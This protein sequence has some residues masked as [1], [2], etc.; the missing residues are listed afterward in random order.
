MRIAL[1][2]RKSSESED[3]QV[4]SLEDQI[5][6]LSRLAITEGHEL[7]AVLQEAKS[8]KAPDS[9]PEFAR[10]IALIEAGKI[11]GI[12]TWSINRLSRN[13]VDGGRLAYML[14]TGKLS[15]I[16]TVDRKYLPDDNALLLSIENGMA[17]AYLQDL[18]RNVTRGM[19]GKADRG[20]HV[21]KAPV[22]YLN[23][24]ITRE[25][26]VDPERFPIVQ[27]AWARLLSGETSV[28]RLYRELP[29]LTIA[30]RHG[31][32]RPL[33]RAGLHGIFKNPI[34]A[35]MIKFKGQLKPGKHRAMVTMADFLRA[36]DLIKRGGNRKTRL[37]EAFPFAGVFRC[38]RCGSAVVGERRRKFYPRTGRF[39]EY[40]YYHCSGSKGCSK[41]AVR[42]EEVTNA[43]ERLCET[44]QL[45]PSF[46]GWL[47]EALAKAISR[48]G[49]SADVS[50]RQ[51]EEET[52]R[53]EARRRRL[54]L[55]RLDGEISEP[56]YQE[57]RTQLDAD[58]A[59][60][61]QDR[62]HLAQTRSK[63]IQKG[64]DLLDAA[65]A[66]GELPGGSRFLCSLG[67]I[68]R[69]LGSHT[70]IDGQIKLK[71]DPI[72]K[73]IALFEPAGEGSRRPKQGDLLPMSS[74]WWT[75]VDDLL[76]LMVD[77]E[78]HGSNQSTQS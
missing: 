73:K 14:Q 64:H 62:I 51:V 72:Y 3:K 11:D 55:L 32:P 70:L 28:N 57:L 58:R 24:P 22:G 44:V 5:S 21:S 47:K 13:P 1:Y 6:A 52:T 41:T 61:D 20:W 42:Q 27:E 75:L 18:S 67:A 46:A 23:N 43:L 35:G 60:L 68:A 33:S 19:L 69:R 71:P 40:L 25:I 16:R 48:T 30:L 54:N 66:A 49:L 45:S 9:R 4:Q 76:T 78:T 63:I 7:I 38:E 26:D 36:Q 39:V 74:V 77:A 2:A 34:Y 65:V 29:P 56:E 53:L 37:P 12:L 59:K 15:M 8:A 10:L 17:T 50:L 31:P